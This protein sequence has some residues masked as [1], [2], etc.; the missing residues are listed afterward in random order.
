M[1]NL[2]SIIIVNFNRNDYTID[3][4]NSLKNQT[5]RNFEVILI[6]NGSKYEQ[7]LKLRKEIAKFKKI[8]NINLI[9]N[10][11]SLYFCGGNNKG[12]KNANGK[13]LC[14]LNNDTEVESNFI[15]KMVKFLEENIDTFL[16]IELLIFYL[17]LKK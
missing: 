3:C 17:I 1:E 4:L 11:I 8:L 5:Y 15:E 2:V 16:Q 13:Y 6:D 7:Y 10:N 14:L 12:I 9:R